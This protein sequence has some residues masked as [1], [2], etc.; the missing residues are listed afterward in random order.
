MTDLKPIGGYFE[1]ELPNGSQ[2]S[3][4]LRNGGVL[5][6]SGQHALEYILRVSHRREGVVWV[7]YYTCEV[8]HE[9]L[10]E[11]DIPFRCYPIN[12]N[13]EIEALP[14]LSD[15]DSIIVNNY[16]GIKDG[17]V[18]QLV[19]HYGNKII[20]DNAQA[21]YMVDDSDIRRFYSPRKFFGLPDGGVA[22]VGKVGRMTLEF[23]ER[24]YS[25]QRCSHL[26]KRIDSGPESGYEDF[27]KNS[28]ELTKE[29][30]KKMSN[31]T[32]TLLR[33]IDYENAKTKRKNN[34]RILAEAF[35]SMNELT[36]PDMESFECPMVY[37][38]LVNNDSLRKK[39]IDNRIFVAS[40]WPGVVGDAEEYLQ[41]YL[42]PLPVDQRYGETEMRRIINIIQNES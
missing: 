40:Y 31:L 2:I 36:L 32:E 39:L 41:K 14:V 26:L 37:P 15:Y 1:L 8:I 29:P 17:Y 6:N 28:E 22:Y 3:P 18:R 12:R 11:L 4:P 20:I 35:D 34:Y 7:P 16:F 38:L 30:L 27:K 13:L 24:D 23:E 19:E 21:W 25:S 33:S 9:K 10:K 42:L 5:V